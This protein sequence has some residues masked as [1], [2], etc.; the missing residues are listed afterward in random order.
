M[1]LYGPSGTGKTASA[2]T[3]YPDAYVLPKGDG[4]IWWEGYQ[5]QTEVLIDEFYGWIPYDYLLRLLDYSP[6]QVEFKG[7]SCPLAATTFIITSNKHWMDW[8]SDEVKG[9]HNNLEA[10]A[11]RLAEFGEVYYVSRWDPNTKTATKRR[12]IVADP[13]RARERSMEREE[14]A[15]I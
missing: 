1:V 6:M 4:K 8:Y 2:R 11:R 13:R 7:G 12:E 3:E 10:L 14:L 5:G 15:F 9:R